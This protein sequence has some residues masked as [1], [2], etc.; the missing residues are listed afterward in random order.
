MLPHVGVAC[1]V[2]SFLSD[3]ADIYIYISSIYSPF[4]D[5]VGLT[6]NFF[7][8]IVNEEYWSRFFLRADALPGVNHMRGIQYQIVQNIRFWSALN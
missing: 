6:L 4:S 2:G 8:M 1:H 5:G 3:V 7:T